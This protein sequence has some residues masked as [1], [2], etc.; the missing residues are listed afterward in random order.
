MSKKQIEKN[1]IDV[2]DETIP[3]KT[4]KK[5]DNIT[6][7]FKL[8]DDAAE[9]PQYAHDGDNGMDIKAVSVSY[10][11]NN[12]RIKTKVAHIGRVANIARKRKSTKVSLN[13]RTAELKF[14]PP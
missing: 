3:S 2:L 12:D 1:L 13:R 5:N 14:Y 9:L 6:I 11:I 8:L 7:K 4:I 10:D